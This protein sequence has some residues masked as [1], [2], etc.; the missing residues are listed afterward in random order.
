M[1]DASVTAAQLA[2]VLAQ[3]TIGAEAPLPGKGDPRN[4]QA[5]QER[6][7]GRLGRMAYPQE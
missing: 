1:K 7:I 6:L 3:I 5:Y 4:L 2:W